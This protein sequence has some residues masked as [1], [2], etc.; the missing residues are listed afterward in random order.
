MSK[1]ESPLTCCDWECAAAN[2]CQEG[3][4]Q[5][6]DCGY[7]FCA[8]EIAD[9]DGRC[10]DCAERHRREMNESAEDEE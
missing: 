5:C 10:D 9:A 3:G 8:D 2:R 6:P 4:F 1:H 7:W